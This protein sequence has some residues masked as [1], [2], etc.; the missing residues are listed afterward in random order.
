M[1]QG[2]SAPIPRRTWG[3]RWECWLAA[4]VG[5]RL[6]PLVVRLP[7]N[8]GPDALAA[9]Y[10]AMS[11][12]VMGLL[13]GFVAAA[14]REA[15]SRPARAQVGWALLGLFLWAALVVGQAL[16]PGGRSGAVVW[17]SLQDGAKLML[18]GF[19]GLLLARW[20]RDR[21]ILLPAAAFAAL[22]DVMMVK[23]G[24]VH[25][26]LKS[27]AGRKLVESVSTAVPS[28]Q[29]ER[30][31]LP[32][33]TIGPADVLF[34]GFFLM[35]AARLRMNFGW[36]AGLSLLFMSGALLAVPWVGAVPA[37]A[38]LGVAF[39]LANW[40]C[41]R[42]SS[43]ERRALLVVGGIIVGLVVGFVLWQGR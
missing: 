35:C 8:A 37:L 31:G 14:S 25:I 43:E 34:L 23:Y 38:P 32:A 40:N 6:L 42:F 36:T 1:S 15:A 20:V 12:L 21:N 26:A 39:L 24:T 28:L 29:P 27:E 16:W 18:A 3:R 33:V 10:A 41:F 22:A 13:V 4:Y 17:G 5:V 9:A 7:A 11:L 30:I 2:K 19:V